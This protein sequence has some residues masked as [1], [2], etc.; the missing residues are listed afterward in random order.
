[1]TRATGSLDPALARL[2]TALAAA[3]ALLLAIS[4]PAAYLAS[5]LA[6]LR[7]SLEA[8]V[9]LASTTVGQVAVI[10]P[11]LW[12]FEDARLR[13][14]LD[15]LGRSP[16]PEERF[17]ILNNDQQ[18]AVQGVTPAW[19]VM[20]VSGP[21]HD[22]GTVV[23]R[24]E[25]RRSERQLLINFG[26]VALAA[27]SLGT[28]AFT[29]LRVVP[30]RMLN[31]ALARS[32]HLA[33]H[34]TLTGLPNRAL[35]HDRLARSLAWSRRDGASLA[36]LFID[37]DNFKD[38]NDS[39]GHAVGDQLLVNVGARLGACL[40]ES[41]TLARFGGDEFAI[42]QA[43]VRQL[44]DVELLAQRIVD[45][46]AATFELSGHTVRIGTSV[47]VTVRT[48]S[49]IKLLAAEA[50]MLLQEADVALYR[51]KEEGR[52]TYRFFE[53]SMN[54]K[55]MARRN[56]ENDLR[57][58]LENGEF[59]LHYQ[60]QIDPAD[61]RIVGAEALLRWHH[62]QNGLVGP[63]D[64][65]AVAEQSGLIQQ[66]GEWVM[67]EACRQAAVWPELECIAVNVS[68]VQFRRAGFVDQ[69]QRAIQQSG[70]D[71]NR[72]EVEIT[73]GVLLTDTPET[74]AILQ[75]LRKMGVKIAM[76]D[77]GTGY[78][79]LGYLQ[80]FRFDKIKIDRSFVCDL[81]RDPHAGE[82]VRAVLR[83]S[84]AMG[85]RVNAEGVE[86]PEQVALLHEE[87][88][89]EVQGFLYGKAVSAEDFGELLSHRTV[90]V[91]AHS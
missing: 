70:L 26:L 33:T 32:A 22:S 34:D 59:R 90:P 78:S 83:M 24:V 50:G 35:F 66:I 21:I 10:N 56:L 46:M 55:L 13:G 77:F 27:T 88:C 84:H 17:V 3:V 4:V 36:L 37:L 91:P 81:G 2:V 87:Q 69:V 11:K 49:Q 30:L 76:D 15:L 28:I 64:F 1:V 57:A 67:Q 52:G 8:E 19:P 85:I 23:G 42:I 9:K 65:I 89:E 12:M 6:I 31:Q 72:L 47:G 86:L 60:P 39:L 43:G 73:E 5:G 16:E 79:S 40:R 20:T 25:V 38:V 51:A 48:E 53:A 45:A 68:P 54:E 63:T 71:P 74:L 14:L 7:A 62:P 58:A 29:I 18:V 80:K 75:R 61:H 44:G 41:D 82:I